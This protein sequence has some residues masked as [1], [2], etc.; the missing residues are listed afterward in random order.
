MRVAGVLSLS[1]YHTY[2]E[3]SDYQKKNRE[4]ESAESGKANAARLYQLSGVLALMIAVPVAA[5]HH[6]AHDS[7]LPWITDYV[8]GATIAG[9]LYAAFWG[10]ADGTSHES[11]QEIY[12]SRWH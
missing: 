7:Q 4:A 5:Y 1:P 2:M 6:L 3:I 8:L 9:G 10:G 11:S 12:Q